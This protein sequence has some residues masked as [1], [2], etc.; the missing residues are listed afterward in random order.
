MSLQH[1]ETYYRHGALATCPTCA[2]G[3][4][5]M[6]IRQAWADFFS[7]CPDDARIL[8][9]GTGNGA[10][11]LIASETGLE[12]GRH[13]EIHASDLAMID[14]MRDVPDATNRMNG[15]QFHAG[16]AAEN[17][18]FD[19]GSF[20]AVSGQYALEYTRM[21]A[22]LEQIFRVLKPGGSAQFIVHHLDSPI[23]VNARKSLVEIEFIL[24]DIKI[25]RHLKRLAAAEQAS[26]R[27]AQ[28]AGID[29]RTAIQELKRAW[30]EAAPRGEGKIFHVTL[31]AVQKLLQL[32]TQ[33]TPLFTGKE[34]DR[35]E[36]ELRAL[37]RRLTDL[38]NSAKDEAG[39]HDLERIASKAGFN[40][41]ERLPQL[42]DVANTIG[43]RLGLSRH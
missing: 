42:H 8:D 12:L 25:Y 28:Q 6:E 20:D 34:I 13:W 9:V 27:A 33:R 31:D 11:A 22:S 5:D 3:G 26:P 18:P 41:S 35:A 7:A 24:K 39:M 43:W 37:G 21:D 16:V 32:R 10:V 15:I 14:P 17:L 23:L 1:W 4:Y 29:L 2:D 38:V 30:A 36:L 19:S 40:V